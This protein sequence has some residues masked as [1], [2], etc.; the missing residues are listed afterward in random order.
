MDA[1]RQGLSSGAASQA[2][3]AETRLLR[4]LLTRYYK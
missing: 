3:Q 1:V 4:I 2:L